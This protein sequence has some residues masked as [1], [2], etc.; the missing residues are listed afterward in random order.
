M[1]RGRQWASWG[2]G[3]HH[4]SCADSSGDSTSPQ[5]ALGM[6]LGGRLHIPTLCGNV[7]PASA[8]ALQHAATSAQHLTHSQRFIIRL[9]NS[10]LDQTIFQ[11]LLGLLLTHSGEVVDAVKTSLRFLGEGLGKRYQRHAVDSAH[12][13]MHLETWCC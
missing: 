12:V 6:S 8:P 11:S 3:P 10:H 1:A 9:F 5:Q 13:V 7:E 4:T 2:S